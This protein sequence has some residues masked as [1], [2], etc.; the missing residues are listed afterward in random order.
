VLYFALNIS[1]FTVKF[2]HPST[3]FRFIGFFPCFPPYLPN[4]ANCFQN[5][6][7]HND[8]PT[9]VIPSRHRETRL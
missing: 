8:G 4:V 6:C 5:K 7:K 9:F 3:T 1:I 2:I